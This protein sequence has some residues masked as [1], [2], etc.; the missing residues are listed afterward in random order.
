M[1]FGEF[2]QL[3]RESGLHEVEEVSWFDS[4][5][6]GGVGDTLIDGLNT[7]STASDTVASS[8]NI[9]DNFGKTPEELQR[10]YIEETKQTTTATSE[11]K[12]APASQGMSQKQLLVVGGGLLTLVFLLK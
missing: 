12:E 8:K 3:E 1:S 6:W 10:N 7:F 4:W 9:F 5:S 11:T 2:A